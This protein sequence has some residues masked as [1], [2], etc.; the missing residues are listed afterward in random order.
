MQHSSKF[1][2]FPYT[3]RGHKSFPYLLHKKYY[4][5]EEI[6]LMLHKIMLLFQKPGRERYLWYYYLSK[7]LAYLNYLYVYHCV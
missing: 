1:I 7:W 4:G 2:G 3:D 6:H 5:T